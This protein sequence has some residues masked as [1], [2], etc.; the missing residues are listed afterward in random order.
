M[1]GSF[2]GYDQSYLKEALSRLGKGFFGV[3]QLPENVTDEEILSL[4]AHGVKAVRFNV[5]RGGIET[6]THLD[7]FGQRV[8]ELAGW[9][10]EVYIEAKLLPEMEDT[11]KKL[12]AVSIDHLGLTTSGFE[13]LLKLVEHGVR[14]KA[15]G[16]GR[17]D[18]DAAEAIRGIVRVN[19]EALMFGSDL[20][21]T[22]APRPFLNTDIE[23]I[24]ETVGDE[25][26]EKVLF[27]N[28]AQWYG[29]KD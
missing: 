29:K 28:A 13:T 3:T 4:D 6:L 2:Q 8:Y 5:K 26:A 15:S 23:L 16:F 24:Q 7:S 25:L 22:R 11:I 9:H 19:P 14:V 10:V 18:M 21:S 1:S 17:I 20:P 27:S 12:P